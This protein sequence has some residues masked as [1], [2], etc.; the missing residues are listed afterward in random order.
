MAAHRGLLWG[1]IRTVASTGSTN[2]D[3]RAMAAA[4][5]TGGTVLV[6][7]EQ[8]AGHGR[9]GRA[10]SSPANTSVAV[11]IL[12]RL[13]PQQS[14][15][16]GWLPL[17]VGLGV[18]AGLA[19]IVEPSVVLKWPNDVLIAGGPRPGKV[20]G[21]LAEA[22]P[23]AG[24]TAAEGLTVVVGYGVNLSQS[25]DEL[26]VPEATSLTLVGAPGPGAPALDASAL[27]VAT[28]AEIERYLQPW[29]AGGADA[30][31]GGTRQAYRTACTTL[32][33]DVVVKLPGGQELSGTAVDVDADGHLIVDAADGRH[34]VA[35]G[36]V[37]HLRPR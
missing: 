12:I 15:G 7:G 3:L 8:T 9:Q 13:T 16:A 2:A 30:E 33:R 5:A 23:A 26:P 18:R 21:I 34:V 14:A 28:L 20:A 36:D 27:V 19:E 32:G 17:I 29:L 31:R 6:A 24:S 10:W 37:V 4:G 11:S 1:P 35:A 22:V 25:A